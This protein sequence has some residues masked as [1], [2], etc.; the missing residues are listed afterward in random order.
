MIAGN[1]FRILRSRHL[2]VIIILSE[3]FPEIPLLKN[4]RFSLFSVLITS[5]PVGS[6][7]PLHPRISMDLE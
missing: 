5:K 4:V 2:R 7:K 1:F 6:A 3:Y